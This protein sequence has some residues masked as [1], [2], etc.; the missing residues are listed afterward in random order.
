MFEKYNMNIANKNNINSTHCVMHAHHIRTYIEA[1]ILGE[2][3]VGI[4]DLI[5]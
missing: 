5:S 1:M 3:T 2:M 4:N